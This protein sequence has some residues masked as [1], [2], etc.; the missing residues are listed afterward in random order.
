MFVNPKASFFP[1]TCRCSRERS[2]FCFPSRSL[3]YPASINGPTPALQDIGRSRSSL[4]QSVLEESQ[5]IS[6]IQPERPLREGYSF[7]FLTLEQA[8]HGQ[9]A[10]DRRNRERIQP[11][12]LLSFGNRQHG[13][14]EG[15]C[16][17][18]ATLRFADLGRFTR[19][20]R[21]P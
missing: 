13:F 8:E 2:P 3:A 19:D 11:E 12:L 1:H 14:H 17:R 4:L 18:I 9:I 21:V 20:K 10:E 15:L 6:T 5:W 16:L 7:S